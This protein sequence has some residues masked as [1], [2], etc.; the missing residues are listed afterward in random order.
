MT[1]RRTLICAVATLGASA[2][3]AIPAA[4]L[5]DGHT[6]SSHIVTLKNIAFHPGALTI[7]RGDS[8]TWEWRDGPTEHNVTFHGFHSKTQS[9]GSYTVRFNQRGTFNYHCTIHVSEGMSGKIIVH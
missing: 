2:A 3:I 6:A 7:K 1:R 4:A 5:G 9:H 8:V